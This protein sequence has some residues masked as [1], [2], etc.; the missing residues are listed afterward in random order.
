MVDSRTNF[1]KDI[2][3]LLRETYGS[4]INVF[5]TDIPHSIRV[6]ES[7]KQYGV[8]VPAIARPRKEGGYELVSGHR[9]KRACELA[10]ISTMPVIIRNIDDDAATIVMV[11]NN[12]QRESILPSELAFAFKVKLEAIKRQESRLDLTCTQVKKCNIMC[13]VSL[14]SVYTLTQNKK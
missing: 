7:V 2:C 12:L 6:V 3:S 13:I 11:D 9:R 10:E 4:N 8:L 1:T 5:G 14:M